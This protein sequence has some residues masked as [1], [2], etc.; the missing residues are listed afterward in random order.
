MHLESMWTEM[1]RN[2]SVGELATWRTTLG[3]EIEHEQI[4]S[5]RSANNLSENL[6]N[7]K[8]EPKKVKLNTN[9]T[10][11]KTLTLLSNHLKL[12]KILLQSKKVLI[13]C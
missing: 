3:I 13:L 12:I 5:N 11:R 7:N 1:K 8:I 9:T 4:S 2:I 6:L 10:M